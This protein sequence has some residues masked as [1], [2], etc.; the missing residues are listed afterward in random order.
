[1]SKIYNEIASDW[2]QLITPVT[3]YKEEAELY[4][5][6]FFEYVKPKTILELGSGAGHNAYY[7]KQWY[8]LALSDVSKEMLKISQSLNPECGHYEGDMRTM[9]LGKTFDAVFIHDAIMHINREEDLE[10]T[11]KTAFAHCKPGGGVLIVPDYVQE[12]FRPKTEYGGSEKD[13]RALRY[14]EWVHDPDF[15]QNTFI[16]DYSYLMKE[17]DGQV[18]S[19]H[20]H[21]IE[22][23]FS[24]A[25]WLKLMHSAGFIPQPLPYKNDYDSVIFLGLRPIS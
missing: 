8:K 2:Y 6:I 9:R 22:G 5:K 20:D 21:F 7:L 12:S 19:D 23:L 15:Q 24:E 16:A 18:N 17:A 4:H 14:L 11:L 10:Q 1:M 25:I 3:E 13:G